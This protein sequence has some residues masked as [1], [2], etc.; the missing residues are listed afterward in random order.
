MVN[1]LTQGPGKSGNTLASELTGTARETGKDL[2]GSRKADRLTRN[3]FGIIGTAKLGKTVLNITSK[4]NPA[5][6]VLSMLP[7]KVFDDI[8]YPKKPEA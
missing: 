2:I 7:K 4:A 5:L 3:A 1:T 6:S 8:L